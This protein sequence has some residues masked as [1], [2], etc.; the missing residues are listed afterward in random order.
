[1]LE[2]TMQSRRARQTLDEHVVCV[3]LGDG[4]RSRMLALKLLLLKG[5]SS[6]VCDR[7]RSIAGYLLP[8]GAFYEMC[9]TDENAIILRQLEDMAQESEDGLRFLVLGTE[10]Y[11][12]LWRESRESLESRYIL[13]DKNR[14]FAMSAPFR[15]DY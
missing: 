3:I 7:Q 14:I 4:L 10:R 9:D 13:A 12:D 15:F 5:I 8:A 11:L 6:V 1:M 2:D